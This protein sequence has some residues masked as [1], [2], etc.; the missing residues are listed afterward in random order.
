[1]RKLNINILGKRWCILG[2]AGRGFF[3]SLLDVVFSLIVA[4]G[5]VVVLVFASG[6][7]VDIVVLVVVPF[8]T[9]S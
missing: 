4:G 9:S 1:M 6:V 2:L 7:F 3:A 8:V 5:L